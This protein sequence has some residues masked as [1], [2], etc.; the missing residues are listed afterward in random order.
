M[1]IIITILITLFVCGGQYFLSTRKSVLFGA[2]L[3]VLFGIFLITM[4]IIDNDFIG[5]MTYQ[6]VIG[7][8]VLIS[9]WTEGREKVKRN[10]K[11]ELEK[12]KAKDL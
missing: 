3:P 7:F 8:L 2:I 9:I 6:S 4:Q 5:K 12:M 11:K 10:K 1:R